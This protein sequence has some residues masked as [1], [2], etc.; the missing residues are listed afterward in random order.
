MLALL[1]PS[2]LLSA[3]ER[4]D[5]KP[6]RRDIESQAAGSRGEPTNARIRLLAAA[7]SRWLR[8]RRAVSRI[9]TKAPQARGSAR[10]SA[11]SASDLAPIATGPL[12][13]RDATQPPTQSN[14]S[15]GRSRRLQ[16]TCE[17]VC[18]CVCSTANFPIASDGANAHHYHLQHL[19][20]ARRLHLVAPHGLGPASRPTK[21]RQAQA[22]KH[23]SSS[24]MK[25]EKPV[26]A[27]MR[28]W[29]RFWARARAW[30]R[31]RIRIP[32]LMQLANAAS[33]QTRR[34]DLLVHWPYDSSDSNSDDDDK[35]T[36]NQRR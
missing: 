8:G 17:S 3:A 9:V 12:E 7:A 19:H 32:A 27:S 16:D 6:R 10:P 1:P 29:L 2:R 14:G 26:R 30:I 31:T 33:S 24:Q 36:C 35:R 21:A 25:P 22:P 34:L 5:K 28:I 20:C 18:V 4:A 13:R 15:E 23:E 11:E